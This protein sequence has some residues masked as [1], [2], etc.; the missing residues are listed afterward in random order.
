MFLFFSGN[1][2]PLTAVK[3]PFTMA[4][5]SGFSRGIK[6]ALLCVLWFCLSSSNNVIIKR[7]LGHYPYPVTVSLSH[8]TCTAFLM[9]PLLL[10]FGVKTTVDIPIVRFYAL[11]VPLGVG[12]LLVSTSSHISIWR[13]PVSYAHTG[14]L[15][16][17]YFISF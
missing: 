8:M 11:L 7:L 6:V 15:D 5:N 2:L 12:K 10:G 9:Y 16:N 4:D 1:G 17:P 14:K 3:P 13:V